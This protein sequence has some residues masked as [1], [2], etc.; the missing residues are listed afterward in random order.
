M[1]DRP[2][3]RIGDIKGNI[4]AIRDLLADKTFVQIEGDRIARAAF[5]RFLEVV[6]EASRHLP[7][8]WKAEHR[9]IPWRKIIDL[10][11]VIRH[12]YDQVEVGILWDIYE[13]ELTVLE[14]ALDAMLKAHAPRGGAP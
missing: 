10:G 7:E 5:E 11:N 1:D 9:E 8:Q 3:L 12:A 6:S 2:I 4:A 14:R 13:H